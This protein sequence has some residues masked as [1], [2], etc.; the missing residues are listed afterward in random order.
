VF[1][2]DDGSALE[3]TLSRLRQ[4]YALHFN[5]ADTSSSGAHRTIQVDLTDAMRRRYPDAEIR[6]RR[7]T[8]SGNAREAGPISITRAHAPDGDGVRSARSSSA[9]DTASSDAAGDDSSNAPK[10]RRM[11][12]DQTYGSSVNIGGPQ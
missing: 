5:S 11:G 9:R 10:R 6:Y 8:L 1:P 4:R 2:V 3:D 7:V 12:V